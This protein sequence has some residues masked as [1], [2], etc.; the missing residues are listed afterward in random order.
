MITYWQWPVRPDVLRSA[1][2]TRFVP[3]SPT[4]LTIFARYTRQISVT[5]SLQGDAPIA[6]DSTPDRSGCAARG[7]GD[8]NGAHK[9]EHALPDARRFQREPPSRLE[10]L[11]DLRSAAG[12]PVGAFGYPRHGRDRRPPRH[13]WRFPAADSR[14]SGTAVA[15]APN[16]GPRFLRHRRMAPHGACAFIS[17]SQGAIS[18]KQ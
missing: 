12:G 1:D 8:N 9:P 2:G 16:R 3:P 4:S 18:C 15:R 7:R 6:V 11:P 17:Q 14:G 5:G 13:E 10:A